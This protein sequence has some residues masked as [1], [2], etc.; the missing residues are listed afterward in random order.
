MG[1]IELVPEGEI[2]FPQ[3]TAVLVDHLHPRAVPHRKGGLACEVGKIL[4]S[5]E[6]MTETQ[7]PFDA[8]CR[9]RKPRQTPL[10]GRS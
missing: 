7:S 6:Q 9:S 2:A 5:S 3:A 1:R 8:S 10:S 4:V